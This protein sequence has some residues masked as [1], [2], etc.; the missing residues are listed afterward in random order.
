[1]R[2]RAVNVL[3]NTPPRTQQRS[4]GRCRPN[5][6]M[7]R[8]ITKAAKQLGLDQVDIRR[9]N[10]PEGKA[11]FGPV[12]RTA[13]ARTSRA[14]SSRRRSIAARGLSTG[15]SA[16]RAAA[17]AGL[18]GA[19]RRRRRRPAWAGSIGWDSIMTHP[20]RRQAVR[21][22]GRRQPGDAL[23]D[24]PRACRRRSARH[25]VGEGRSHL[26]RHRQGICHGR[27]SRSAA[28]RRMG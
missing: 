20:S 25:A 2:W 5:G 22:V 7:E 18:E 11:L 3:T 8:S 27:A 15:T 13:S 19:W 14:R 9:I 28:R 21:P 26:G 16:R 6:I 12:G 4:P 24:R 10:S 1:M 17:S 23:G